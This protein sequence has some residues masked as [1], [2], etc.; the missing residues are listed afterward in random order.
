M[1]KWTVHHL[2]SLLAQFDILTEAIQPYTSRSEIVP[3]AEEGF[4]QTESFN[5]IEEKEQE[6]S[7]TPTCTSIQL[8]SSSVIT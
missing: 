8:L 7:E 5:I 3:T 4:E 6:P 1:Q 2:K